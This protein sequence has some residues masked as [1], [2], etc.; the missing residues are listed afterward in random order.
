MAMG[1]REGWGL[2]PVGWAIVYATAAIELGSIARLW[3]PLGALG[4]VSV[5]ASAIPGFLLLGLL[6]SRLFSRVRRWWPFLLW[7]GAIAA[8]P[9]W[10]YRNLFDGANGLFGYALAALQEEV[11]FRAAF[12][13]I[14]WRLLDRA[15]ADPGWSRAGAILFPAALFSILPY[16]LRQ[17]D[18]ALGVL[19]F[20]TFAVFMGLLVRRPDVLPAAALAHMTVNLLTVPVTYGAVSPMARTLAVSVLLGGFVFIALFVAGEPEP[21]IAQV[22]SPGKAQPTP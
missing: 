19:P 16:H 12:P 7:A 18:S 4:V 17:A 21:A 2:S 14:V 5:P 10:Y 22:A 15:G 6:G 3:R 9:A 20:F 8:V 13:L 11:V 1:E